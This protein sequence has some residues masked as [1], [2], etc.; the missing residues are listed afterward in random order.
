MQFTLTRK[1]KIKNK[2]I[3]KQVGFFGWR[4]GGQGFRICT[5]E[6][7]EGYNQNKYFSLYILK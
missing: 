5:N 7:G 2:A 1:V 6:S 4:G 3:R